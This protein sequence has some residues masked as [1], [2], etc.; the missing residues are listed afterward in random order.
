MAATPLTDEQIYHMRA[1]VGD[2]GEVALISQ[3]KIEFWWQQAV[4]DW[5]TC[6]VYLL[7]LLT[8]YYAKK[9]TAEG[10]DQRRYNNELWKHYKEMLTDAEA[11]T[12]M[13]I[14]T[15]RIST[16][17]LNQNYPQDDDVSATALEWEL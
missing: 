2:E 17:A 7:R 1:A 3:P 6:V 11:R 4:G 10:Q 15:V 5:D 16:L 9:V 12:G 13:N 8:A 14:P